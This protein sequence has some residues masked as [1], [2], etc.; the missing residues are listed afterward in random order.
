LSEVCNFRACACDREFA[1]RVERTDDRVRHV[2][3]QVH[4]GRQR[5]R[6]QATPARCEQPALADGLDLASA[7]RIVQQLLSLLD[8]DAD[9]SV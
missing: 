1:G 5:T 9:I 7:E 8:D 4:A 2:A 3:E 6:R